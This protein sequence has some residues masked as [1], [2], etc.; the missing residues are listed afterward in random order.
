MSNMKV[1][2]DEP[3]R[4]CGY[5]KPGLYMI[6]DGIGTPCGKL[7]LP[8]EKCP[9]GSG[10]IKFARGWTWIGPQELFTTSECGRIADCVACPAAY[11][12]T[13]AG[14]LWVGKAAYNTPSAFTREALE[15]GVSRRI[16]AVP[17]GFEVGE[18]WV[19][20][21]HVEAVRNGQEEAKPGI[22]HAFMPS[23]IE[24]VTTGSETE[25]ELN[26]LEKR[27]LS[28]VKLVRTEPVT[29]IDDQENDYAE[30]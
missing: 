9:T 29:F 21:A 13:R 4:L 19:F 16:P 23:R 17:R 12:P 15:L 24:Y 28:L 25:E 20:V 30:A 3:E 1:I 18:T 11:P 14:L 6:S 22:F 2:T 26:A 5:R 27:G 8:L 7:P 10:G